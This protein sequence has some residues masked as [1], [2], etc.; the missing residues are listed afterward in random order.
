MNTKRLLSIF[1]LMALT[2]GMAFSQSPSQWS[3]EKSNA[4]YKRAGW[5]SGCNYIPATAINS[6]EMWQ[7]E[8]FDP[9]TIDKELGWAEELGFNTMRV[10]LNSLVWK[11]DHV[12]FRKRIDQYLTIAEKHQITTL[13][14]FFDDC[15][16]EESAIGKQ[17]APKPGI[18]NSGWVQDPARSLRKDSMKL[19]ADLER[20]VKDV[21]EAF[22]KDTRVLGWDMYNEPGPESIGL[23]RQ[24]YKW[25]RDVNPDQP[26]TSGLNNL[27]L[28]EINR[29]R[30][31]NSDII[32][33]HCYDDVKDQTYWI[34]FLQHYGR[35]II[36]TE[37]MA[38]KF[39]CRFDN[40]M[41]LFKRYNVGA[42]NWGFV[43]GKTN[44]IFAWGD[45]RPDGK[46]PELWFHD[47][48]RPDKTP[49][50]Q[51]EVDVI[52]RTNGK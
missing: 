38:R 11:N 37:Y 44:T 32:T 51:K 25:A 4:W 17:P 30:L 40:V 29:F 7:K 39:N 12:G 3:R 42:I 33:F 43:A 5:Q 19:Y 13:F 24:C 20:Y 27:D 9:A 31:E 1:I 18:H 23:L 15:W 35:P 36:C 50:D 6:V 34:K 47:I 21:M 16:N 28:L 10:F 8:S 48:L 49:F 52:K 45:P 22:K 14:V 2:A 26:V 41:P 46:E